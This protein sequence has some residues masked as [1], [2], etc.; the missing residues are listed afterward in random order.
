VEPVILPLLVVD[1]IRYYRQFYFG[2]KIIIMYS[3]EY[4]DKRVVGIFDNAYSIINKM[5]IET[6]RAYIGS[7]KILDK[8]IKILGWYLNYSYYSNDNQ[9]SLSFPIELLKSR[10]CGYL[11]MVYI[12]SGKENRIGYDL[13][14]FNLNDICYGDMMSSYIDLPT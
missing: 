4:S 2:D 9:L 13:E 1:M 7:D 5:I 12:D 6:K 11:S 10:I 3:G 14:W 8:N